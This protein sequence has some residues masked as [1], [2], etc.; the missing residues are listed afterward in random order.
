MESQ[1]NGCQA[2]AVCWVQ[3]VPSHRGPPPVESRVPTG[4]TIQESAGKPGPV[5]T[6][7]DLLQNAHDEDLFDYYVSSQLVLV[8]AQSGKLK[9]VGAPAIFD[10]VDRSPDGQHILVAR[11]VPPYSYV[12]PA[13]GF[14][15]QI[16]IWDRNGKLEYTR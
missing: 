14:A 15:K 6:Y 10:S 2:A 16:E 8:D 13:E 11:I 3:L 7:E 4:P 12:L 1:C 9:E 5:P